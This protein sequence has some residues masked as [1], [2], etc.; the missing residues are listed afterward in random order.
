MKKGPFS[1]KTPYSQ[2]Q[3]ATKDMCAARACTLARTQRENDHIEDRVLDASR[4]SPFSGNFIGAISADYQVV[5]DVWKKGVWE[6]QAKS[7]SSGSRRLFLHFLGK[8][9][10]H[11]MSGKRP[12]SP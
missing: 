10:V 1:M 12:R 11:K 2:P 4:W 7:G 9:A 8:I 3:G 5:A 6:F